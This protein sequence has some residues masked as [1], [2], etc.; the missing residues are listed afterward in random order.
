ME[1]A[2]NLLIKF[3]LPLISNKRKKTLIFKKKKLKN[4]SF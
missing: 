3:F 1:R 4:S 2:N